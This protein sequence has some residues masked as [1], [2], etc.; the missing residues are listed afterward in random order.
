MTRRLASEEKRAR[1]I[2]RLVATYCQGA[3]EHGYAA[4]AF[5]PARIVNR[6]YRKLAKALERLREME[7][8]WHVHLVPLL[9]HEDPHIRAWA[10]VDLYKL[11]PERART[12]MEELAA[13]PG[14]AQFRASNMLDSWNRRS[15]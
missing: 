12:I 6:A 3:Y 14:T 11:F 9:D 15:G 10:A 4:S 13:R 5:E 2:A 1:R 7:A 8:D